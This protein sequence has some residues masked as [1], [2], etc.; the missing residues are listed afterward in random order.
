MEEEGGDIVSPREIASPEK[1]RKI[2][3]E[4][5]QVIER[6]ENE[7]GDGDSETEEFR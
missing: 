4:M 5:R 2:V 6:D 3:T 7:D 1:E